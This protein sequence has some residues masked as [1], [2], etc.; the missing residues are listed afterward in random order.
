MALTPFFAQLAPSAASLTDMHTCPDGVGEIGHLIVC[1]RS[2]TP[3]SFR[4]S[5]ARDGATDATSQYLA[6]DR[7]ILGNAIERVE[8]ICL[9]SDDV[10]R[11]YATLATLTF[12]LSGFQIEN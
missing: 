3:T 5:I 11:A 1:N 7:A 9:T 8:G 10:V 4:V 12:T 6:Y 2:A